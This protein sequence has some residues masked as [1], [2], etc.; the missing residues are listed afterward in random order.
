MKENIAKC[1]NI[2]GEFCGKRDIKNLTQIELENKYHIKQADV[3]VLF[4]GSILCGGDVL[5][6]AIRNN[7]GKKYVI[8]GGAGHTTDTLRTKVNSIYS[9]IDTVGLSEAE[10]FSNYL[11]YKYNLQV[12][13][14]EC[15]S[16]NC[17]NNITY[18]LNLLKENSI[19]FKSILLIQDATMQHRME[20]GLKKYV[21][22]DIKIINYASYG[23]EVIFR[24]EK[25][26]Y[27]NNILGMWDIE[28]YITLLMGEIPRLSDNSEGYGPNGKGYIAHVHIDDE[29]IKAFE[30]LKSEYKGMVRVAN[31]LY[32]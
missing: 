32:S 24:E 9:E 6:E 1:I 11:K 25:L 27:K 18:L 13:L 31:P 20:A 2:L 15:K 28:R 12:D 29:V 22:G 19:I 30:E 5:A 10:I 21:N 17:G 26:V 8:V 4:G 3:V 7:I 23:A 14:L 16:T